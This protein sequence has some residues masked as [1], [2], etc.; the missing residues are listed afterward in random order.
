MEEKN[1]LLKLH[2]ILGDP[3]DKA[4]AKLLNNEITHEKEKLKKDYYSNK[5]EESEG[6]P[7]ETWNIL[8]E[9]TNGYTE[10]VDIEPDAMNKEKRNSMKSLTE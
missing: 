4:R 3:K 2:Y 1:K 7:K 5:L 10:K 8:K 9:L 6:D